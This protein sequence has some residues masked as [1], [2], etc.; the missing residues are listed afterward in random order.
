MDIRNMLYKMCHEALSATD[1]KSICKSRG[2]PAE[3]KNS[4]SFLE[5]IFL[6]DVGVQAALAKLSTEEVALLHLLTLI[7]DTVDIQFFARVYGDKKTSKRSY[8]A[9]FTQ[10]YAN[11]FKKTQRSLIRKGVLVMAQAAQ[12][13]TKMERWRFR[14]PKE[15]EP[16]LPPLF[17]AAKDRH[18]GAG[19]ANQKV[20]RK[21]IGECLLKK[22]ASSKDKDQKY[23][24][25]VSN[26]QLYIGKKPFQTKYL[27]EWQ[28][29][30]WQASIPN[31]TKNN[32]N[33]RDVSSIDFVSYAFAQLKPNEWIVPSE[34]SMLLEIIYY[35]DRRPPNAT[36]VCENGW[37]WGCL[38]K[39][40]IGSQAFY[41]PVQRLKESGLQPDAYL[42]RH[43]KQS[44]VIDLQTIPYE[45]LEYL[46]QI[47]SFKVVNGRLTGS[48]SL[49]KLGNTS[50]YV[51]NHPLGLWLREHVAS[52]DEAI[53]K[54]NQRWGKQIVHDNLL[55]ARIRDLSL[56]VRLQR[57]FP[58]PKQLIVLS[59]EF[60]AFPRGLLPQVESLVKK[61]GNVIK[62]V[63]YQ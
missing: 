47:S 32:H 7:G 42:K 55:V 2:F 23:E 30:N 41:G 45:A 63:S 4:K 9:T 43:G 6:S 37:Q 54:V 18:A 15:F 36:Q 22:S 25:R 60:V 21:K 59:N 48:A 46:A 1:I 26:G 27:W 50:E 58:D 13:D 44:V 56:K 12:G 14:F 3:A 35:H 49:T 5:S 38:G 8:H 57:A 11:V 19:D 28:Q 53:K 62:K 40:V 24:V 10:R 31:L 29:Y 17:P 34:L 52:F 39:Q 51:R 20:L 61:T 33:L 16:F